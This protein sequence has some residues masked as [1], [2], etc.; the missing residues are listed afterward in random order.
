MPALLV[1]TAADPAMVVVTSR[2]YAIT[3]RGLK[4]LE[5]RGIPHKGEE[6]VAEG[7]QRL[8]F[9]SWS[10]DDFEPDGGL[11]PVAIANP[12]PR[13][14][15]PLGREPQTIEEAVQEMLR[16]LREARS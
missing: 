10:P 3:R 5:K 9:G 13:P 7:G 2:G 11:V 6:V 1:S 4:E 14:I 12:L 8:D 15:P 16:L